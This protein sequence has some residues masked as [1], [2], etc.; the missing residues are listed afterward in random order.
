LAEEPSIV[1]NGAKAAIRTGY[2]HHIL[3]TSFARES[4]VQAEKPE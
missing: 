3:T 4:L 1:C 2:K